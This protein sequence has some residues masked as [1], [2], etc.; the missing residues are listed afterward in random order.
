MK[1]IKVTAAPR[2]YLLTFLATG[3]TYQLSSDEAQ[4]LLDQYPA[5]TATRNK[6]VLHGHNSSRASDRTVLRPATL[7]GGSAFTIEHEGER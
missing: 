4:T 2:P 1:R 5:V 7:G 6:V 3:T